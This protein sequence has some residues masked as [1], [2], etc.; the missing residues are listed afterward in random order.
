MTFKG[1]RVGSLHVLFSNSLVN[2]L[3]IYI[4]KLTQFYCITISGHK[5]LQ[6]QND[7]NYENL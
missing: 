5:T 2:L 7:L 4:I 6:Q 3:T 1:S